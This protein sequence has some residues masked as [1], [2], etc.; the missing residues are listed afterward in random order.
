MLGFK[1]LRPV[2]MLAERQWEECPQLVSWVIVGSEEKGLPEKR[3]N[4]RATGRNSVKVDMSCLGEGKTIHNGNGCEAGGMLGR[5]NFIIIFILFCIKKIQ[6]SYTNIFQ[7]S[8]RFI[9]TLF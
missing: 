9:L 8:L 4:V 2:E 6:L 5:K 7:M 3:V 1:Y